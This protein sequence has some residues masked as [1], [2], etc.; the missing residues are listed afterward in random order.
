MQLQR[1]SKEEYL[2][3]LFH[4]DIGMTAKYLFNSALLGEEDER[5]L[6]QGK[7]KIQMELGEKGVGCL[8]LESVLLLMDVMDGLET[9]NR[10]DRA[11]LH[12]L[13]RFVEENHQLFSVKQLQRVER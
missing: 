12:A 8:S 10:E 9:L 13:Y 2:E 3:Q 4:N 1:E 6:M 7:K 5:V 11:I